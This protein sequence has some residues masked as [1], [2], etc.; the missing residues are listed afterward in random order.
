MNDYYAGKRWY[1]FDRYDCFTSCDTVED[2]A[3]QA[4]YMIEE[5][6]LPHV[7]IRLFTKEEFDAYCEYDGADKLQAIWEREVEKRKAA[8]GY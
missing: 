3:V 4:R 6:E 2:A 8:I 5:L 1:V 7:E